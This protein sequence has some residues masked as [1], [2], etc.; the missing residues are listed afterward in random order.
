MAEDRKTAE[1]KPRPGHA[2]T[3]NHVHQS[4]VRAS[5]QLGGGWQRGERWSDGGDLVPGKLLAH[6]GVAGAGLQLRVID[7]REFGGRQAGHLACLGRREQGPQGSRVA[8][9]GR[10]PV[11]RP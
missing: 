8:E 11:R 4:L 1:Q 2:L 9:E 6:A 10:S 7:G 5:V 3:V